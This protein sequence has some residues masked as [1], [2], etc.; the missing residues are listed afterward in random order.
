VNRNDVVGDDPSFSGNEH[1][2]RDAFRFVVVGPM[3][4]VHDSNSRAKAESRASSFSGRAPRH[5]GAHDGID[6]AE[7]LVQTPLSSN[8]IGGD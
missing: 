8:G 3:Q 4:Q 5:E 6:F 2:H 1:P 7:T